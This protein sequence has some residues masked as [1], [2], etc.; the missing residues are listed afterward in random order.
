[1]GV[2]IFV[3]CFWAVVIAAFEMHRKKRLHSG[4][5]L[6]LSGKPLAAGF[7][8][9][10]VVL[11]A[12]APVGSGSRAYADGTNVGGVEAGNGTAGGSTPS[13]AFQTSDK[14]NLLRVTFIV[15]DSEER[16]ANGEYDGTKDK[17]TA[18]RLNNYSDKVDLTLQKKF[19]QDS[20]KASFYMAPNAKV[21][22]AIRNSGS[23]LGYYD[24]SSRTIKVLSGFG[25][26]VLYGGGTS[27]ASFEKR[28]LAYA[29]VAYTNNGTAW[30][31]SY[32]RFML[33]SSLYELGRDDADRNL[34][35]SNAGYTVGQN[36]DRF[37]RYAVM[38]QNQL[39]QGWGSMNGGTITGDEYYQ[40][41]VKEV[42]AD[43]LKL[44]RAK[45]LLGSNQGDYDNLSVKLNQAL[46]DGKLRLVFQTVPAFYISGSGHQTTGPFTFVPFTDM[47]QMYLK[48]R[49]EVRSAVDPSIMSLNYG[50]EAEV[51]EKAGASAGT[52]THPSDKHFGWISFS[53]RH[54]AKE[55][56]SRTLKPVSNSVKL[57]SN[58]T[59]NPFGGWGYQTL[60]K[61]SDE[62]SANEPKISAVLDVTVVD[63][64]DK[65]VKKFQTDVPGWDESAKKAI[66]TLVDQ[67]GT[68]YE[69]ITG[70]LSVSDPDSTDG[71]EYELV[72]GKARVT[73]TDTTKKSGTY[74]N[75]NKDPLTA[76]STGSD[77][78]INVPAT[79]QDEW[80]VRFGFTLPE[81]LKLAKYLGG[82]KTYDYSDVTPK[83][84]ESTT[85]KFSNAKVTV[86]VKAKDRS[87]Y[88]GDIPETD[89]STSSLVVPQWRLSKY[90]PSI[91]PSGSY[92]NSTFFLDV[93]MQT[94]R[95]AIL[96]PSGTAYFQLLD[97]SLTGIDWALS[98]AKL[99]PGGSQTHSITLDSRSAVIPEHGDLLAI[100]SNK[101]VMNTKFAQWVNDLTFL[102]RIGSTNTGEKGTQAQVNKAFP[103]AYGIK[104]NSDVYQYQETRSRITG[105]TEPDEDG[106]TFPIYEDYTWRGSATSNYNEAVYNT[107][108]QFN[109]F[110][111][112]ANTTPSQFP[113]TESA[114]NGTYW[115][116]NQESDVLKVD[117]EV[118]MAYSDTTGNTS[119]AMTAGDVLR[120]IQPVTY[121]L[122][123]YINVGVSPEVNGTSV[124]TDAKAKALAA[125]LS[126]GG[127]EVIHK[128]SAVNTNF[129]VKG[130]IE[131]KTFAFD[132]GQT[133]LKNTWNSG[134]SYNTD[135]LNTDFLN[136]L[137]EKDASGKWVVKLDTDGNLKMNGKEVG[138]KS[139]TLTAKQLT[140]GTTV[141]G[142]TVAPAVVEHKLVIRSGKL[143][144]VDGNTNLDSLDETLKNAL[145]RAKITGTKTIFNNFQAAAGAGLT[146][147]QFASLGNALRGTSDLAT[148]KGWYNEDSTVLVFR[149]YTTTFEL[150][151][152]MYVDKIPMSV[153]GLEAPIN[154][155][156]YYSKGYKGFT[157][158]R[159]EDTS[160]FYMNFDSSLPKGNLD[161]FFRSD[162]KADP[163]K[164]STDFVVPNVSV[165]DTFGG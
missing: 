83:Y 116:T 104:N 143:F 44:V 141:E 87:I 50:R 18:N 161:G 142:Y 149:E 20:L 81:P 138:G 135:K 55:F 124:A 14:V 120:T 148:G 73:L 79:G 112:K 157:M 101:D 115:K 51:A 150:P 17:S 27:N 95:D 165:L 75:I 102:N 155:N 30:E 3:A 123:R 146:E 97:P 35:T 41:R 153:V 89:P 46:K 144:S 47:T 139:K 10:V 82:A 53:F 57:T 108:V 11:G 45:G 85:P 128:G 131:L 147:A 122:A 98:K 67:S 26:N 40:A 105:Y 32:F 103:F 117:P 62:S 91:T 48:N 25:K 110:L 34:T 21:D 136:E 6:R 78:E 96:T 106:R 113:D 152:Y 31:D 84:T 121:N 15:A 134:T 118:A 158:M 119:V 39:A 145:S 13:G 49:Q 61:I 29:D 7:L 132:I 80:V 19:N 28:L 43:Y 36:I 109:R 71:K 130:Q 54:Y 8:A 93:P 70:G 163:N 129:A 63:K 64:D 56:Y 86:Y 127:K 37:L 92:T 94:G 140:P 151:Q 88:D 22:A 159:F 137:A 60:P 12:V 162:G 65:V 111:P 2:L 100:K 33:A 23:G 72:K 16:D 90:W 5:T 52:S 38:P 77:V 164:Q 69:R 154:K 68:S 133:S 114:V 156:Q 76:S 107:T 59:T 125:S 160:K 24:D 58:I 66:S 74:E 9:L 126:S 99:A 42:L 1:M 4:V